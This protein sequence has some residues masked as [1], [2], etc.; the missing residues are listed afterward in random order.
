MTSVRLVTHTLHPE[1]LGAL[2]LSVCTLVQRPEEGA[3]SGFEVIGSGESCPV[4]VLGSKLGSSEEQ[5]LPLTTEP[6][7]QRQD[8]VL[9]AYYTLLLRKDGGDSVGSNLSF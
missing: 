3:V 5:C 7:A 8:D 1:V 2:C 9:I 6:S 4:W